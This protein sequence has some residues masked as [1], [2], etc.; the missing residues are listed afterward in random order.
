[1]VNELDGYKKIHKLSGFLPET[2]I[3]AIRCF[4]FFAGFVLLP[5]LIMV[6]RVFLDR[7]I[8]FLVLCSLILA[9]GV[10]IEIYL[11]AHYLAP[12]TA[13][14]YAIGLQA[15]R[16]LRVWSPGGQPVGATIVRLLIVIC[17]A[18]AGLRVFTVP[19]HIK[20]PEWPASEWADKWYG[21]DHFGV[22]R[23]H[24]EAGLEQLPGDQLA[25]VRYYS[26]SHIRWMSGSTTCRH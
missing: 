22:Q 8:R 25:I 12:F 24:I 20:A 23:A 9:A 19:L 26:G 10:V 6:R 7:R 5:P 13:V 14:F 11:I 2:S 1:M 4:E 17:V 15:M 3:K 18:L 16:H 21:P